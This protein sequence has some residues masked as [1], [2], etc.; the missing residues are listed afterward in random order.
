TRREG[1]S[2]T[3]GERATEIMRPTTVMHG[4]DVY[5]LL[6]NYGRATPTSEPSGKAGWKLFLV[7]GALT[8]GVDEKKIVWGKP[9]ALEPES[10]KSLE[11]LTRLVGGGGSGVVLSDGTLVF[12]MQAIKADG[13]SVL[14]AMSLTPSGSKWALSYDTT[15]EGCRDPSIV[16]WGD[17]RNLLAMAHCAGGYYDVYESSGRQWYPTGE[18]ISRVWGTSL[19]RQGGHGVQSGFTTATFGDKKVMLLTTPVYSAEGDAAKARL[20]LWA[21]DMQRVYDVGA[22][23]DASHNAAASSLLYRSGAKEELIALYEKKAE[24]G[25][26]YSLVSVPLTAKLQEIRKW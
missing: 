8:D 20:H 26:S 18:P 9:H 5:M 22:V 7:K 17:D 12:P 3:G 24:A 2:D 11:S 23:S 6:G 25:E 16:E 19:K 1:A 15:G 4:T 10:V 13:N 14:L 21:T